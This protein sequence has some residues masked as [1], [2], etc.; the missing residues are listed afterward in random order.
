MSLE[1]NELTPTSRIRSHHVSLRGRR[2]WNVVQVKYLTLDLFSAGVQRRETLCLLPTLLNME[3]SFTSE[4]SFFL[5]RAWDTFLEVV[6]ILFSIPF[7]VF[8]LALRPDDYL[9]E[10][11][12]WILGEGFVEVSC[13]KPFLEFS[14]KHFLVWR[15]GLD[16][17]F[18]KA[19]KVVPWWV[20]WTLANFKHYG[21]G[22]LPVAIDGELVYQL[23]H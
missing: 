19:G 10:C 13:F 17:S 12:C 1:P 23:P 2:C 20:W 4:V 11:E 15:D 16:G 6:N 5:S 18:V 22:H 3:L 14:H 21:G 8:D 7:L 9:G